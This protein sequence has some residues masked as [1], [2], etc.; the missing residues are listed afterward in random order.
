MPVLA[1]MANGNPDQILV[2]IAPAAMAA[3][4]GFMLPVGTPPNAIVFGTGRISMRQM[5]R[6]GFWIDLTA[7]IVITAVTGVVL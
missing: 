2:L 7:V 1:A 3:S 6:T 4:A 5:L